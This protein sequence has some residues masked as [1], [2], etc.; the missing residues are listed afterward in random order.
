MITQKQINR[1]RELIRKR[2]RYW[3]LEDQW[4][5]FISSDKKLTEKYKK[6]YKEYCKLAKELD[7]T[8]DLVL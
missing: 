3:L 6:L 1:Q 8:P 5:K 2:E 4:G 7:F